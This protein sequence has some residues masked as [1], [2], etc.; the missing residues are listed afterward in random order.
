MK[1]WHLIE[2]MMTLRPE[3][4]RNLLKS[5]RSVKVKRLFLFM[6]ENNKL[7]WYE[8]L[9]VSKVDLG[10]CKRTMV[11]NEKLD[12]KY[13]ITVPTELIEESWM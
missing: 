7:P 6:A 1:A 8:K 12:N 2:G 4:I 9:D 13:K 10:S 3:L 11:K 5:C